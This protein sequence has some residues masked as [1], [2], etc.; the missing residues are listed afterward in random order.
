MIKILFWL[1]VAIDT[2]ALIVFGLL[3]LAAAGSSRTNPLAALVIPFFIPGALLLGAI[4]LFLTNQSIIGRSIAILIA[5][6]PL[7]FV[8]GGKLMVY[9]ELKPFQDSTGTVRQF[10]S[11]AL[12][13]I[14]V[15]IQRNDAAAVT[16]AARGADLNTPGLSGATVLV[17]AL[18]QLRHS[19]Q[20]LDVIRALLAAGADPNVTKVELP[21]Q[22]AI[23]ESRTAGLEPVRL[24]LDAGANPNAITESGDPVFFIAGGATID[25]GVMRLLVDRGANLQLK[26]KQGRSAVVLAAMVNN[27]PVLE[28]LLKKG[29]PWQDQRGANGLPFL[30][31]VESEAR[32]AD[33]RANATNGWTDVMNFLRSEKGRTP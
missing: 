17:L 4:G 9:R 23:S 33:S 15:A 16:T 6:A 21:L 11:P 3:G 30:D 10:R 14:E 5:S 8:I 18:R 12:R 24:L 29:A 27:W 32:R 28:F 22:A 20:Q 26:D 19:P 31:Y 2:V 25:V 7:L 13:D 1:L